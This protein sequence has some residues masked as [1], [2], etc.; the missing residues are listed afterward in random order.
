MGCRKLKGVDSDLA[1]R[2]DSRPPMAALLSNFS[3]MAESR[4]EKL[5]AVAR[6]GGRGR[7]VAL[8]QQKDPADLDRLATKA[9]PGGRERSRSVAL[10]NLA[11]LAVADGDAMWGD[12]RIRRAVLLAG[13]SGRGGGKAS[14]SGEGSLPEALRVL[15]NL[16]ASSAVRKPMWRCAQTR[17]VLLKHAGAVEAQPSG[18]SRAQALSAL[19][20]LATEASNREPMWTDLATR[21]VLL[22]GAS[23]AQPACVRDPALRA[24]ANL[25]AEASNRPSMG[26]PPLDPPGRSTA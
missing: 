13:A 16:A 21:R 11:A 5:R 19:A 4:R 15:S 25:S 23:A 26:L 22:G 6:R 12:S 24:L 10:H 8:E 7:G 9:L 18:E 14:A 2:P 20:N 17:G 1:T 3:A